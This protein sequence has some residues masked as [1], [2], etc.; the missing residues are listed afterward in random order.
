MKVPY[1][2]YHHIHDKNFN[3]LTPPMRKWRAVA[4]DQPAHAAFRLQLEP[5]TPK[6]KWHANSMAPEHDEL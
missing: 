3:K 2:F 4:A 6:G 1:K 5:C